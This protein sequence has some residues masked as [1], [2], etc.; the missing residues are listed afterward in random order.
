MLTFADD[1][2]AVPDLVSLARLSSARNR[3]ILETT[4][5]RIANG[6][7]LLNPYWGF[8]GGADGPPGPHGVIYDTIREVHPDRIV[9]SA[10][11]ISLAAGMKCS[12]S[13]GTYVEVVYKEV[14]GCRTLV[15]VRAL[16]HENLF[17]S[18]N[19]RGSDPPDGGVP[20]E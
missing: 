2:V 15:S 3:A 14:A 11:T 19:G 12:L 4:R 18:F 7:L 6:R 8:S 9:L 13:A 20:L 5:R 10:G 1:C 16:R 17:G